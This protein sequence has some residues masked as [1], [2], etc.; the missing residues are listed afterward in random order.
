MT[1]E[2][3]READASDEPVFYFAVSLQNHGP[4]E[5][6]RYDNPTH[7]VQAPDHPMG[8]RI[9]AQLCRRVGGTRI[10]A[11]SGS[12]NGQRSAPAQR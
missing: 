11:S 5:P 8:A 2:I 9:A 4:Y 3:I 10:T 6:R 1:D 12:S 7:S